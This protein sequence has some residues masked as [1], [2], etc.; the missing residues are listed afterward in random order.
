MPS[1]RPVFEE[2]KRLG[3]F[4]IS[5]LSLLPLHLPASLWHDCWKRERTTC[6]CGMLGMVQENSIFQLFMANEANP[7]LLWEWFIMQQKQT[8]S[9]LLHYSCWGKKMVLCRAERRLWFGESCEEMEFAFVLAETNFTNEWILEVEL[10]WV[11]FLPYIKKIQNT[12]FKVYPKS[13]RCN[14]QQCMIQQ[15]N[16]LHF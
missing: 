2:Y 15:S 10:V 14:H 16:S 6:K 1:Q 5:F 13:L 9:N 3:K 11:W 8:A 4:S 12:I 7:Q